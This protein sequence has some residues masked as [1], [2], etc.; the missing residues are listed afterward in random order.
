M[1][2]ITT[3]IFLMDGTYHEYFSDRILPHITS[4]VVERLFRRYRDD[5][6]YREQW[7]EDRWDDKILHLLIARAIFET[8][9]PTG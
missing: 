3:I 9:Y 2:D 4:L 7:F 1:D 5:T 6:G 8:Q